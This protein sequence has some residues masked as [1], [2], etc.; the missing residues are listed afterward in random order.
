MK[1]IR[2]ISSII[3]IGFIFLIY[4]NIMAFKTGVVGFTKKGGMTTGC[5]CHGLDPN[6]SVS[7]IISGPSSVNANDTAM[8]T[9]KIAN[10]PGIT[11]GCDVSS[12]LGNVYPS[13]LDTNL[14]RE[15]P[16]PGAGFELTHKEPVT[17]TGDTLKFI[18]KYVAPSTPNV[19]DTIFANGNSTN[20][21]I[22]SDGDLWNYANNFIVNITPTIGISNNTNIANS[23]DLKQNYPNPFNPETII[24]FSISKA[25]NLSLTVFDASGKEVAALIGN[26]QY[27]AGDYSVTLN[28]S[29][30]GLTTGVYF[31]KL[32]S[33]N[34]SE[35]KK[36]M[37]IK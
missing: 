22:S 10:G 24:N 32:S 11:G 30:Y 6:D 12:S 2:T 27:T 4:Q 1:T 7:V 29:Q 37:L 15:E 23:F 14:K 25:S 5:V 33:Q 9:L 20:N 8:F 3:I 18:F 21:N 36:M 16:F 31:Y 35:V 28:A 19:K 34:F 26:K 17:F 13:A